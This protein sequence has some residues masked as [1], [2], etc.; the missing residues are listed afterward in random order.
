MTQP[1]RA[2]WVRPPPSRVLIGV[3]TPV[4]RLHEGIY[5]LF[6]EQGGVAPPIE[7]LQWPMPDLIG[8][9]AGLRT[10]WR[11]PRPAALADF[12]PSAEEVEPETMANLNA[13]WTLEP[14]AAA[15]CDDL[16]RV[17]GELYRAATRKADPVA[18]FRRRASSSDSGDLQRATGAREFGGVTD[19]WRALFPPDS[20][21]V[22]SWQMTLDNAR[23]SGSVGLPLRET[24][25]RLGIYELWLRE[26]DL[27]RLARV[28]PSET[29]FKLSEVVEHSWASEARLPAKARD[30]IALN[31]QGWEKE[32]TGLLGPEGKTYTYD[33]IRKAVSKLRRKARTDK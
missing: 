30:W 10:V 14:A 7:F 25:D 3:A 28:A 11:Y 18:I 13:A 17:C 26:G 27:E 33:A 1:V 32:D 4:V 2:T 15:W 23:W 31:C 5:A 8:G 6:V 29:L 20:D 16:Y 19:W 21:D 9:D 24:P 22:E 12:K